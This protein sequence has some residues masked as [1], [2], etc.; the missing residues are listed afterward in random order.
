[1]TL[2]KTHSKSTQRKDLDG[3]RQ[4]R[5]IKNEVDR[6]AA[7]A[8]DAEAQLRIGE[9]YVGLGLAGWAFKRV[10]DLRLGMAWL[11]RATQNGNVD[12]MLHLAGLYAS[13]QSIKQNRLKAAG[14]FER[15]AAAGSNVA[16]SHLTV[17]SRFWNARQ[18]D[19]NDQFWIGGIHATGVAC[20]DGSR[21]FFPKDAAA[22]ETCYWRAA[23]MGHMLARFELA[24]MYRQQRKY[25]SMLDTFAEAAALGSADAAVGLGN[26]YLSGQ[27]VP[28]DD[29]IAMRWFVGAAAGGH[30]E[31]QNNLGFGYDY[32]RG[33]VQD[34]RL[35]IE[36]YMRSAGQR[37][38]PAQYNLGIAHIDGRGVSVN[39]TI[40]IEWFR[41]A[42][43]NKDPDATRALKLLH[44]R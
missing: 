12:A 2:P 8:G 30:P 33:V 13:A 9:R 29:A 21:V 37:F 39:R 23:E 18:D 5:D 28:Q 4:L 44:Q 38:A 14:L 36:W 15:A 35:A 27:G 42:A 16:R 31:G 41:R 17:Y 34:Q 7:E 43:A 6:A 25:T 32:G 24:R 20:D 1:M 3:I 11:N 26:A 22:A 10:R 19:A 40:A